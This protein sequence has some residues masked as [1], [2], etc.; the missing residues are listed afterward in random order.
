M[1]GRRNCLVGNWT[2]RKIS[3]FY[4]SF[5]SNKSSQRSCSLAS[6]GQNPLPFQWPFTITVWKCT[7]KQC[8]A[9]E[10]WL[11]HTRKTNHK[12][13]GEERSKESVYVSM[14]FTPVNELL[15]VSLNCCYRSPGYSVLTPALTTHINHTE[16]L[17][18]RQSLYYLSFLYRIQTTR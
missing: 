14:P 1:L 5:V 4:F 11:T 10:N 7:R 16:E 17:G 18:I 2:V 15:I 13:E 9:Y 8:Q 6:K 3:W 12:S